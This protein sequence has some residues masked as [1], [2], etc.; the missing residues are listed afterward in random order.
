[1]GQIGKRRLLE[2]IPW[3]L[4]RPKVS[5]EMRNF[6]AC[7]TFFRHLV[8]AHTIALLMETAGDKSIDKFQAI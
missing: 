2:S 7:D 4:K 5:K 1:M 6:H 3:V 8:D